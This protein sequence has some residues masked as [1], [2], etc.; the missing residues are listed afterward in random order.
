ML[1]Q[2]ELRTL[3]GC[4]NVQAKGRSMSFLVV[5]AASL[6]AATGASHG[7]AFTV[8]GQKFVA[9]VPAGECLPSAELKALADKSAAANTAAVTD[10]TLYQCSF[11]KVAEGTTRYELVLTPRDSLRQPSPPR[12]LFLTLLRIQNATGGV[13]REIDEARPNEYAAGVIK[14]GGG[15]QVHLSGSPRLIA[16]DD[17]AAYFLAVVRDK[18]QRPH[19]PWSS[20]LR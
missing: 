3:S 18:T 16:I 6:L 1:S 8:A 12:W 5:L 19:P 17:K 2:R 14:R 20:P 15:P 4:G 11:P 13:Q 10:L 7:V 9:D